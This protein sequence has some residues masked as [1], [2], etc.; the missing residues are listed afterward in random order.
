MAATAVFTGARAAIE[1]HFAREAHLALA[2][3]VEHLDLDL[4]TDL[5]Q[6]GRVVDV[7]PGQLGDVDEAVDAVKVHERAE[8]D[9]VGDRALHHLAGLQLVEDAEVALVPA[10]GDGAF[11]AEARPWG[12]ILFRRNI[13]S[14]EQVR[15]LTDELRAA[16]GD[17]DAPILID[18][19][20]GRVQRMGPP[21][22]PKYPPGDAYLKATNDP[23]DARDL[24]RLGARL[25]AHDLR[26]VGRRLLPLM[27]MP[28]EKIV[29][30]LADRLQRA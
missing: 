27:A 1:Q 18:Q 23:A 30:V 2:V 20:G 11:F 7:A 19:E 13:D 12:F 26:E 22:W 8:V 14:P 10:D 15:A 5:E 29:A 9:D 17:R 4:L 28:G 6:L 25:M 21:H 24:V 3:D 16:I